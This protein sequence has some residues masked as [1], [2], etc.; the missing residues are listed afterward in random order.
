MLVLDSS[1]LVAALVE[2]EHTG[3]ADACVRRH[4]ADGLAA[5]ALLRWEFANVLA[6]KVR[7]RALAPEPA[8]VIVAA[9]DDLRI[10]FPVDEMPLAQLL[11]AAMRTGLTVYDAA[12]LELALQLG[13]GLATLDRALA[14]AAHAAGVVVEAP[15]A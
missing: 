9:F 5:P 15:F 1:L 2:E 11:E 3:F 8:R 14:S 12:Y 13:A 6:M 10:A 7:R 4:A